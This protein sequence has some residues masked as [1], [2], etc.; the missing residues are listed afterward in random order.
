MAGQSV[1]NA[2]GTS[3]SDRP[4]H[5]V[6]QDT[7]QKTESRRRRSIEWKHGVRRHPTQ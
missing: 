3:R 2:L 1:G 7:D 5:P 6:S 4:S